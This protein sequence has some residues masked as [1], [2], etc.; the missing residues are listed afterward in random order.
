[1][2]G[3][4]LIR[5]QPQCFPSLAGREAERLWLQQQ[6]VLRRL[7]G[8]LWG[9]KKQEDRSSSINSSVSIS[10][11]ISSTSS[12]GVPR[13]IPMTGAG[14]PYWVDSPEPS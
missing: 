8:K 9:R 1:M 14:R 2:C 11:S 3:A 5:D 6:C 4:A 12:D 10:I 7:P 13:H